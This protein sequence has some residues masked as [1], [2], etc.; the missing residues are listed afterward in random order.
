MDVVDNHKHKYKWKSYINQNKGLFWSGYR[1]VLCGDEKDMTVDLI[2][3]SN[4]VDRLPLI[5]KVI[6]FAVFAG[7]FGTIPMSILR[8][9]PIW[10]LGYAI[11]GGVVVIIQI[12][13][14][15]D[16]AGATPER[17]VWGEYI[18]P[19]ERESLSN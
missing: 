3:Y 18:L 15:F 6:F 1:C 10:W 13:M 8:N 19:K 12:W 9:T 11:A 4:L 7:F 17:V 16:G 14:Y 5:G 2:G